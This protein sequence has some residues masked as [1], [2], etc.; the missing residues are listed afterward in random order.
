M[1]IHTRAKISNF[2]FQDGLLHNQWR[3]KDVFVYTSGPQLS[4]IRGSVGT[5]PHRMN[6]RMFG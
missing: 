2:N 6:E 5:E 1:V 4:S 3:H